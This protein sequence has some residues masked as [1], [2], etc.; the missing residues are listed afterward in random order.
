MGCANSL[1]IPPVRGTP[2]CLPATGGADER[3]SVVAGVE[4]AQ[5]VEPLPHADELHG[6]PELVRDRD[7]DAAFRGAVELRQRDAGHAGRLGEE[8]RLLDAVLP[9]RRVDDEQRLVR[10]ALDPACDDAADLGEL[11]HQVALRVEPSGR[12]DDHD[13]ASRAP[14]RLDRVERD[15]RRVGAARAADELGAGALGPDLELLLRRGAERVRG[16]DEDAPAVLRELARELADRR[17][18]A[19]AVDADDEDDGGPPRG[20][21]KRRRLAEERLDLVG[22]RVA[23]VGDLAARLEPP[24]ELGRRRARRRRRG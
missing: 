21:R 19:G 20:G 22:E 5:V 11:L 6:Q 3:T 4:R 7:R 24:D 18:L 15:G 12:V 23:E 1:E 16:A 13:V 8:A 17:R 2:S 9:G 10:R 14:A